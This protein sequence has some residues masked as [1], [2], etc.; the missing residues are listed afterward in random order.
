MNDNDLIKEI[1]EMSDD[2]SLTPQ[3]TNRL[4]LKMMTAIWES[5]RSI[6]D[7]LRVLEDEKKLYPTMREMWAKDPKTAFLF[8]V[9]YSGIGIAF[10]LPLIILAVQNPGFAQA[11]QKL[12]GLIP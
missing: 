5:V 9:I 4:L 11:I 12:L 1:K 2:G 8:T 3:E 6:D 10:L 7:R